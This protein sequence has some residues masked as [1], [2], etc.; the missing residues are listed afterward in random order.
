MAVHDLRQPDN[1]DVEDEKRRVLKDVFGFDGFRPGQEDVVDSLLAGRHTL[2]VMPT[3][4]GKS[5]CFQVP[6]LIKGGLTVV[7]SPLVALMNNQ[8]GALRLAGVRAATINSSKSRSDN[9]TVWRQ[10]AAGEVA[11]LYMSPE[12]LMT[13]RMLAALQKL[14]VAYLVI[15]EAHCISQWGHSF[16]PEYDQLRDLRGHFPDAAIAAMTATA[17]QVTRDDIVAALFGG[18]GRV[19]VAGFDRPNIRLSVKAKAAWLKQLSEVVERYRGQC[20]IVYCLSRA[21]TE[22][23]ASLLRDQ[24]HKAIAYHAGLDT[25]E[26]LRGEEAFL[27]EPGIVMVATIAFGMGIDKPDVRFVCHT[28]LPGS[29]EAYY[30][31]IG[32]A[33]RDGEPAEAVMVYGLD[34]IRMRRVFIEESDASDARKRVDHRRLDALLAYCEAVECRRRPLLAYF[35]EDIEPCGNCDVCLDGVDAIDGTEPARQAMAAAIGSGGRFGAAHLVDILRGQATEKVGRFRHDQ[36]DVF[37]AGADRKAADWRSLIR[38]LVAS[39]FLEIDVGGYGG[40]LVTDRGREL[41]DGAAIFMMRPEPQRKKTA[42]PAAK[43]GPAPASLTD[44]DKGLYDALKR[45]RRD[46]AHARGVPPYVVF[47]DRTL[48]E[49][50]QI[51][52]TNR[53]AFG[54]IHGVGAAKLENFAEPFL[55]LI[56][57]EARDDAAERLLE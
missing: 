24:G 44:A 20:G 12:R 19:H 52:P 2:A 26:R 50:A 29:V 54:H 55:A 42:K 14:P 18:D 47:H 49:L 7:V 37:G 51:R 48:Q 43:S 30:Q 35:G 46:I 53:E 45:L 13:E 41:A 4:A 25:A 23:A 15:D 28:D 22:Q 10:V 11:I 36:L 57:R 5:L 31:E 1:V 6:A 16:R 8:V 40:L 38:Q 34:D 17:D 3:G 9:V 39:G 33:G 27:T 32:R 21:K 56:R